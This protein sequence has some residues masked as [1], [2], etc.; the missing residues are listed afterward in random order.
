[1]PRI[2]SLTNH[3]IPCPLSVRGWTI[4]QILGNGKGQ[5][6]KSILFT[7]G[8]LAMNHFQSNHYHDE[9]GWFIVSLPKKEGIEPLGE[10]RGVAVRIF[11]SLENLYNRRTNSRNLLRLCKNY[12]ACRASASRAIGKT[13]WRGFYLPMHGVT[14]DSNTT[15]WFKV[16]FDASAKSSFGTSL[17]DQLLV[18]PTVHLPLVDVLLRFHQHRIALTTD[19]TCI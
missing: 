17:N 15:T 13:L 9:K 2:T 8:K 7:W 16:G 4:T 3:I 5:P 12:G 1:M 14:K 19:V 10:S 18:G 6:W 11:L